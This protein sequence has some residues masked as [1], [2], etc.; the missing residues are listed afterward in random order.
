M[1][2]GS[3]NFRPRGLPLYGSG[4]D[5]MPYPG[6]EELEQRIP[7]AGR[8]RSAAEALVPSS[9]GPY[10]QIP[11]ALVSR[12]E[13]VAGASGARPRFEQQMSNVAGATRNI[14]GGGR[15]MAARMGNAGAALPG[16][17]RDA[18]RTYAQGAGEASA[19]FAD[20]AQKGTEQAAR[21]MQ[22]LAAEEARRIRDREAAVGRVMGS[23]FTSGSG[24]GWRWG[25][26]SGASSTRTWGRY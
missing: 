8:A 1:G 18:A 17:R 5:Y 23:A 11:R 21:L 7:Y 25:G 22:P 4:A 26:T 14:L 10:S 12:I 15:T 3:S 6:L 20:T 19:Q 9:V 16:V 2:L 24:G 13:D